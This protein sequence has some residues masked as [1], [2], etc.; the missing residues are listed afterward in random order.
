MPS[1]NV[2]TSTTGATVIAAPASG[3]FIRIWGYQ[4]TSAS[5]PGRVT[6]LTGSTTLVGVSS[7]S[8]TGGGLCAPPGG[9]NGEPYA[10]GVLGTAVTVG[11]TNAISTDITVQYSIVG[12]R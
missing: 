6:L 11:L 5:N 4:I 2:L 1:V 7:F 9:T 12:P 10:D 8:A 3:Q